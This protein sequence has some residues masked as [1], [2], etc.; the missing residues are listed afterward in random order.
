MHLNYFSQTAGYS[1]PAVP[2]AMLPE[3]NSG[4]RLVVHETPAASAEL[5]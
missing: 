1:F 5:F 2:P 4:A 3:E